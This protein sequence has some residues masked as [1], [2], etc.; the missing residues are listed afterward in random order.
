MYLYNTSRNKVDTTAPADR[1]FTI[2]YRLYRRADARRGRGRVN[3]C[4]HGGGN[5][6]LAIAEGGT[7]SVV[8]F[9]VWLPLCDKGDGKLIQ[10]IERDEYK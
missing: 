2:L 6:G 3:G 7:M 4:A 8:S 1:D 10:E 9:L 5:T